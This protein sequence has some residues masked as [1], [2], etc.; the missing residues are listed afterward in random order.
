MGHREQSKDSF[1]AILFAEMVGQN[2]QPA[3]LEDP[4]HSAMQCQLNIMPNPRT[5]EHAP[6]VP[7]KWRPV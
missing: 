3:L 5:R 6:T 1:D 2:K 7:R 4:P